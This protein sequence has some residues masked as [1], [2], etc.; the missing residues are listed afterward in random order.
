MALP[1]FVPSSPGQSIRAGFRRSTLALAVAVV[2]GACGGDSGDG[3]NTSKPGDAGR[4]AGGV[5]PEDA[6][7]TEPDAGSEVTPD[8]GSEVAPDAGETIV[9]DPVHFPDPT[10]CKACHPVDDGAT[11]QDYKLTDAHPG[12]KDPKCWTCHSKPGADKP[13]LCIGCHNGPNGAPPRPTT[14]NDQTLCA[15]CHSLPQSHR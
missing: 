10:S 5:V 12:W 3:N 7:V 13:H 14:H 15:S 4:D 6:G 11:P 9:T 8:A 2:L 1:A